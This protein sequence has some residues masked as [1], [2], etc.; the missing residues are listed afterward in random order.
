MSEEIKTPYTQAKAEALKPEIP[1]E[2]NLPAD[3]ITTLNIE[4]IK[5]NSILIIT[6]DVQSPVQKMAVAPVFSKLLAPYAPQLR[7]K[8]VTVMLMTANESIDLV[9]EADMNAAGWFKKEK[10]LIINPFD[11]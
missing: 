8:G 4:D 3:K 5:P 6:I 2:V 7:E 10:S 1:P 9:S 11:K